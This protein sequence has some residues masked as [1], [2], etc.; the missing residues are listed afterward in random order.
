[1]TT[2]NEIA[3][4]ILNKFRGGRS[5]NNDPLSIELVIY[6]IES[7]RS[8]FIR[9]DLEENKDTRHFEQKMNL[10]FEQI[11]LNGNR[12]LR[13]IQTVPEVIRAKNR[14]VITLS[15]P[16]LKDVVPVTDYRIA[17]LAKDRRYTVLTPVAFLLDGK[18]HIDQDHIGTAIEKMILGESWEI[19]PEKI[20]NSLQ[21]NAVF[22]RPREVMIANGMFPE[23]TLNAAYP[24]SMEMVQRITE[25]MVKG[26]FRTVAETQT[27]G[28]V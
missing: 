20:V 17:S 6:G 24:I 18:I 22:E 28:G 25:Y 23:D 10:T 8:L 3:Y 5:T 19:N 4:N 27:P 1:M 9:R 12:M 21:L 7:A 14:Q 16:N 11:D 2:L 15:H 13:S 26:E